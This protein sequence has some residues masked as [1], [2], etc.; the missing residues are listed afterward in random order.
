VPSLQFVQKLAQV[1]SVYRLRS[2]LICQK[3][4]PSGHLEKSV[5]PN[6]DPWDH[7]IDQIPTLCPPPP[8][9]VNIDRCIISWWKW[10]SSLLLKVIILL[11]KQKYL[12]M[13]K[14]LLMPDNFTWCSFST[15]LINGTKPSV[16]SSG[17]A[18]NF[19]TFYTFTIKSLKS[20]MYNFQTFQSGTSAKTTLHTFHKSAC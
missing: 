2:V 18:H 17:D 3:S 11:K 13:Y 10:G 20:Q 5:S 16:E 6:P 12:T 15:P 1:S 8:L 14:S 9:R 19:D 4:P 7:L